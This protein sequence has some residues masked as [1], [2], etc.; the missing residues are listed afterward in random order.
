[1]GLSAS[2][3]NILEALARLI[4]A[5]RVVKPGAFI[6]VSGNIVETER[7]T[8]RLLG[9]DGYAKDFDGAMSEM[10]RL[11]TIVSTPAATIR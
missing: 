5:L 7:D 1:M 3:S 11:R 10:E 9:V 2:G 4:V 6:M 8:L